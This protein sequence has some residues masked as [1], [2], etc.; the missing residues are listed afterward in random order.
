MLVGPS[1]SRIEL[2]L[3]WVSKLPRG[4]QMGAQWLL[5]GT[6]LR[7]IFAAGSRCGVMARTGSNTDAIRCVCRESQSREGAHA[8]VLPNRSS[9]VQSQPGAQPQQW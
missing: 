9:H 4:R 2:Q 6:R 1:L 8:T 5:A 3:S 7:V